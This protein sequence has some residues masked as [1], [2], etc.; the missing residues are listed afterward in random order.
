MRSTQNAK[1]WNGLAGNKAEE[2][3]PVLLYLFALKVFSGLWRLS[4]M[5]N[6]ISAG[7]I[8]IQAGSSHR[9]EKKKIKIWV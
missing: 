9:G 4:E 1:Q 8:F 3:G 2:S 6:T 7:G 5:E